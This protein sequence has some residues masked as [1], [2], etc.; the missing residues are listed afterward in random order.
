MVY[1]VH[2]TRCDRGARWASGGS[3][4]GLVM[5]LHHWVGAGCPM[6][7]THCGVRASN[8][9]RVTGGTKKTRANP[10]NLAGTCNFSASA[11]QL[12]HERQQD[13]TARF[14]HVGRPTAVRTIRIRTRIHQQYSYTRTTHGVGG[15]GHLHK[16]LSAF[17]LLMTTKK[18]A[19]TPN[20]CS[21]NVWQSS[22]PGSVFKFNVQGAPGW[23][24]MVPGMAL[25]M[26]HEI[27]STPSSLRI[28]GTGGLSIVPME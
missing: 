20:R 11:V 9:N 24:G 28:Y 22:P 17:H 12:S 23:Q 6:G 5:F 18:T 16:I 25:R 1:Q 15:A 21:R 7:W 3:Y 8:G 4:A 13:S 14:S 2:D 27:I 19:A 26:W 10:N